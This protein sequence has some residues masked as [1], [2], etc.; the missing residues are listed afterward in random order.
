[1][2]VTWSTVFGH[3][4]VDHF[5]CKASA[6]ES[7]WKWK[8]TPEPREDNFG[9]FSS[10]SLEI[11][12]HFKHHCFVFVIDIHLTLTW[13]KYE[14]HWSTGSNLMCPPLSLICVQVDKK[15]QPHPLKPFVTLGRFFPSKH[16]IFKL[17]HR[18]SQENHGA[19]HRGHLFDR[20]QSCRPDCWKRPGGRGRRT[21]LHR[22]RGQR[23]CT[24]WTEW[25]D[26]LLRRRWVVMSCDEPW[27]VVFSKKDMFTVYQTKNGNNYH[28]TDSCLERIW[29]KAVSFL[30][31][32]IASCGKARVA[33][34]P[35]LCQWHV[36]WAREAGS[37][38]WL[39]KSLTVYHLFR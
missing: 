23:G 26:R 27:K 38:R 16:E 2:T 13:N 7:A 33:L 29:P 4:W 3:V 18:C 39:L 36:I 8:W 10:F 25:T 5:G 15:G 6:T 28:Q 12:N 20:H 32:K 1:M 22:Q 37:K 11:H 21:W 14:T 34:W 19:E 9:S 35:W 17:I 31:H 24:G 30:F